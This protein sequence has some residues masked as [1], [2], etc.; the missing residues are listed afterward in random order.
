MFD[1]QPAGTRTLFRIDPWSADYG[2]SFEAEPEAE[3]ESGD[4]ADAFVETDDWSHGIDPVPRPRPARV[5]FVDGVQRIEA[6]GR[7]QQGDRLVEA[8]LASIA[9]GAS[10][11]MDGSAAFERLQASRV[12]AVSSSLTVDPIDVRAGGQ[13][14]HFEPQP[15]Q[16]AGREGVLDAVR[17]RRSQLERRLAESL[18]A[19]DALVV[20]DGRLS[21]DASRAT[22]VIGFAKT[23]QRFY[24]P[25]PQSRLVLRLEER[26]RTPVFRIVFGETV[27]YSWYLRLPNTR[28]IHHALAGVVR[29]E[30]PEIGREAAIDLAGLTACHLPSFASLPQHDPRAPQNLLPVGGLERRLRH[31]MGDPQ[32][33]RR[34]IEDYLTREVQ[35]GA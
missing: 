21:F 24:L 14:L 26:Q 20:L 30:T 12:L 10:V 19:P 18:I 9:V 6:W 23:I 28:P 1:S 17:N 35:A 13:D 15:S 32:F 5:V 25:E 4:V 31:E 11:C 2:A 34:A 16:R 7:L 33:I 8:A 29:L 27:R 22:P 3:D